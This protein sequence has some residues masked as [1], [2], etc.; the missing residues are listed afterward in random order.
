MET[1]NSGLRSPQTERGAETS[2]E[3]LLESMIESSQHPQPAPAKRQDG[4]RR[5]FHWL[6]AP[7]L[8]SK[9]AAH[10][11]LPQQRRRLA[12]LPLF[13]SLVF[14]GGVLLGT[15]FG[16]YWGKIKGFSPPFEIIEREGEIIEP[17]YVPGREES[18][19]PLHLAALKNFPR[20]H[21]AVAEKISL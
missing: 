2:F 20:F 1:K 9:S 15:I 7:L 17:L 10:M 6:L 14:L 11:E 21:Y 8:L 5:K 18:L 12:K 13:L 3:K 4:F 19:D 16:Y